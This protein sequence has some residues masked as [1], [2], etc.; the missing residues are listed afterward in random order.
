MRNRPRSRFLIV[1]LLLFGTLAGCEPRKRTEI[2]DQLLVYQQSMYFADVRFKNC[3][4]RAQ[5][6]AS[7]V[8]VRHHFASP[9]QSPTDEQLTDNTVPTEQDAANLRR[10]S[11]LLEKC[12]TDLVNEVERVLPVQ[13]DHYRAVGRDMNAIVNDLIE[14]KI[15]WGES[16]KRNKVL[17]VSAEEKLKE[18][19][20]KRA[21]ELLKQHRKELRQ[22]R[23][24]EAD[25]E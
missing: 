20:D 4:R 3:L 16:A 6:D 12:R 21:A 18:I 8:A 25:I 15:T 19:Q 22:R 9:P 24:G 7:F 17:A 10:A 1:L 2:E 14:R 23:M 5:G 13:A 11:V